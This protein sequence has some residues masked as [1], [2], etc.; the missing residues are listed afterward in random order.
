MKILKLLRQNLGFSLVEVTVAIGLLG[1]ASIAV[2]KLSDNVNEQTKKSE[3][4][5]SKAQFLSSLSTY[6]NS[7]LAC[8][9]DLFDKSFST[10]ESPLILNNWKVAGVENNPNLPIQSGRLFKLFE[11]FS[12]TATM[13]TTSP[14]L[15]KMILGP[16]TVVK[17][18]LRVTVKLKVNQKKHNVT[19]ASGPN[20]NVR[21]YE[22]NFSV[23]V[24]ATLAGKIK[25]C[26][27]EKT[28]QEICEATGGDWCC[29]QN[30]CIP[31]KNCIFQ[32]TFITLTATNSG[33]LS[34]CGESSPTPPKRCS[35]QPNKLSNNTLSCPSSLTP[36]LT[37]FIS[38]N[39][40][41]CDG[42]KCDPVTVG[43]SN[44]YYTCLD[45]PSSSMDPT[46]PCPSSGGSITGGSITGGSITGGSIT[47]GSITGGSITGGSITGGSIDATCFVAGTEIS[48]FD[49]SKKNIE[50]VLV[51]DS[52][53]N[54]QGDKLKVKKVLVMNYSG[55]IYSINGGP[56][57]F[58]PNHPFLTSSGWKSLSPEVSMLEAPDIEVSTL[59]VGDILVKSTGL[60]I[61][62]TL[63]SITTREKVYN[64]TLN[65]NHQ[66]IANDFVVHNKQVQQTE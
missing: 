23:P 55:P 54:A 26:S 12:L 66:Y 41:F 4:I 32:G 43:Y 21:V 11:L 57:F 17:T 34:R 3:T 19:V 40:T 5:L 7:S 25:S 46:C 36:T 27:G 20:A 30:K 53:I 58:T 48:L 63:D 24:L 59:K 49:G 6:L 15:E 18:L 13:D 37:G 22:H 9:G 50:D 45:C 47:G 44:R 39:H 51:G 33:Y 52:L 42:K 2:M 64:F 29:S 14:G 60:E 65:G 38:W 10:T 8:K 35:N 56:Y 31:K 28:S 16:D 62:F 1:I 61:V